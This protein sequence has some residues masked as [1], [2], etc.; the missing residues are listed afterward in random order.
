MNESIIRELDRI[1]A[2]C[3]AENAGDN[4]L[5]EQAWT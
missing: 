3:R 2:P 5:K 4:Q 1:C